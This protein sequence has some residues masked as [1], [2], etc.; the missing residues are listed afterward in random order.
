MRSPVGL[1]R[2][3]SLREWPAVFA[4]AGVAVVVEIGLRTMTLPRLASML[5]AP[6]RVDDENAMMSAAARIRL[7]P[8][9]RRRLRATRRVMRHWP[10]GD[11]CLRRA[12][13]SGQRIRRLRPVLRVGVAKVDGRIQAH[14]WLEIDGVA[15]DPVGAATY[16]SLETVRE[17]RPL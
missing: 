11:T 2:R 12:L 17:G 9:A 1:A 4:A 5:G 15:L 14:A 10:L 13:V 7:S 3:V 16:Q 8:L 6:L